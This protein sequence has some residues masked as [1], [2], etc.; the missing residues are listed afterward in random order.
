MKYLWKHIRKTC[1]MALKLRIRIHHISETWRVH[2]NYK[3]MLGLNKSNHSQW[4]LDL[5]PWNSAAGNVCSPL[6]G[7]GSTTGNWLD[8]PSHGRYILRRKFLSLVSLLIGS[9]YIQLEYLGEPEN[10]QWI[11]CLRSS[12]RPAIPSIRKKTENDRRESWDTALQKLFHFGM[13]LEELE[14]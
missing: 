2:A 9:I 1:A 6:T 4:K 8:I 5:L 11:L 7:R 13:P 12:Q 10:I 14:V 3:Q